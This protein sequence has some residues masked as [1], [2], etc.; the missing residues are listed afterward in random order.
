M[1]AFDV[2]QAAIHMSSVQC[3]E[4]SCVSCA[5]K[6][7]E[8]KGT[9]TESDSEE[10]ETMETLEENEVT[11]VLPDKPI[12]VEKR[13]T[14]VEENAQTVACTAGIQIPSANSGVFY[15]PTQA[16]L[17]ARQSFPAFITHPPCPQLR[18]MQRLSH[19]RRTIEALA[20]VS[21]ANY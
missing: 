7:Y 6:T 13:A 21:G 10:F 4:E 1:S 17:T 14:A 18:S 16:I 20:E 8:L 5:T 11:C 15:F 12:K 9:Q 19:K 2:N 3:V